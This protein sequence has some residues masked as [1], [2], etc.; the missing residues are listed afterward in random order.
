[1]AHVKNHII[2]ERIYAKRKEKR[3]SQETVAALAG[4]TPQHFGRIERGQAS[5]TVDTL[6]GIAAALEVSIYYLL[7]DT[8]QSSKNYFYKEIDIQLANVT[9]EQKD[10][11]RQF[12]LWYLSLGNRK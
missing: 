7:P 8:L 12:L 9:I 6:Y 5:P 10:F 4:I 1:M 11:I 2:A 3:L